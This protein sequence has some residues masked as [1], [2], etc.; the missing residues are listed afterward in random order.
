MPE[1]HLAAELPLYYA[2]AESTGL[3]EDLE[4][5]WEKKTAAAILSLAFHRLSTSENAASLF[6]SWAEGRLLPSPVMDFE[7]TLGLLEDLGRSQGLLEAFFRRRLARLSDEEALVAIDA[8]EA[9]TAACR[10][11]YAKWGGAECGYQER[12]GL[13]LLCGR[14]S[15][16]PVLFRRVPGSV[17]DLS[18]A[19]ECLF[20][21]DR[22]AQGRKVVAAIVPEAVEGLER[23]A[24]FIDAESPVVMPVGRDA[25]WVRCAFEK[26]RPH[27]RLS[28][29]RIPGR[30][31]WGVSVPCELPV[32]SG[33]FLED[34]AKRKVWPHVLL[35]EEKAALENSSFFAA[36]DRFE[37]E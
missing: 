14:E 36:L 30:P 12:A 22:L 10:F 25:D 7:E 34:G 27:L 13:V 20:H 5:V 15:R 18:A 6:E 17:A 8:T 35:S 9:A 4:A 28:R 21:F 29:A 16:M 26:A 31:L 37:A 23:L 2:A 19:P 24:R 3:P 1:T 33:H 11:A 32:P